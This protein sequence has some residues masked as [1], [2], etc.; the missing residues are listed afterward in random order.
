MSTLK[1]GALAALHAKSATNTTCPIADAGFK[2]KTQEKNQSVYSYSGK[3]TLKQAFDTFR[4]AAQE[5]G[6]RTTAVNHAK[7]EYSMSFDHTFSRG[8]R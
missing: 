1:G 4:Q 8:Y 5:L 7:G 6:A 3:S 2:L